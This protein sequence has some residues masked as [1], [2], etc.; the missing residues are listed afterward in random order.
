MGHWMLEHEYLVYL[1]FYILVIGL[2]WLI[3]RIRFKDAYMAIKKW[4]L[5][6]RILIYLAIAVV[7]FLFMIIASKFGI[8]TAILIIG[9]P[10]ALLGILL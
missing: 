3:M 5:L 9:L 8:V 10:G 1:S 7:G 6:Y 2:V 4:K